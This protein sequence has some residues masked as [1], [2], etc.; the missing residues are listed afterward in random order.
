MHQPEDIGDDAAYHPA[1]AER[2]RHDR[3]RDGDYVATDSERDDSYYDY[4]ASDPEADPNSFPQ[5]HLQAEG[6]NDPNVERIDLEGFEDVDLYEGFDYLHAWHDPNMPP[7]PEFNEPRVGHRR[8]ITGMSEMEVF[9]T[10]MD[11]ELVQYICNCTNRR[12][13]IFF[14]VRRDNGPKTRHSIVLLGSQW[15]LV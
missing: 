14:Q 11:I 7:L 12:A 8:D 3:Y 4:S 13:E 2:A 9:K 1:P 5:E 10:I 6:P 15:L